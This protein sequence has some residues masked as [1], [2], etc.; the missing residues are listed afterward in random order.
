MPVIIKVV[1]QVLNSGPVGSGHP[2]HTK[3]NKFHLPSMLTMMGAVNMSCTWAVQTCY[4][5]GYTSVQVCFCST[6]A[7]GSQPSKVSSL[8]SW[9]CECLLEFLARRQ[10]ATLCPTHMTQTQKHKKG[11]FASSGGNLG[12]IW[13]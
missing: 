4:G 7:Q 9:I 5:T 10:A 11:M 13:H 2:T 12:Q 8:R 6:T 1:T 3:L